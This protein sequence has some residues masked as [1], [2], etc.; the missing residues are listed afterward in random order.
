MVPI[1]PIAHQ[2]E[3]HR[4]HLAQDERAGIDAWSVAF[5][6]AWDARLLDQCRQLLF[7]IKSTA[8]SVRSQAIVVRGRALLE[9]ALADNERAE[10]DYR[11]SH[12][13]F[14]QVEDRYLAGRALNDLGTLY[15]ARGEMDAAI[16][17]Y[18]QALGQLQPEWQAAPMRRWCATTLGWLYFLEHSIVGKRV[19]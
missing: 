19:C 17:C 11:R 14:L 16:D 2:L 13:L 3:Y 7:G 18:R 6:L 1:S 9:M 15:Q 5:D 4:L 12:R 10:A 8:L